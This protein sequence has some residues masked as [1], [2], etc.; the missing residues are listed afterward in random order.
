LIFGSIGLVLFISIPVT[1]DLCRANQVACKLSIE[2]QVNWFT[3]FEPNMND[4]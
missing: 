2:I 1:N 3:N 4:D